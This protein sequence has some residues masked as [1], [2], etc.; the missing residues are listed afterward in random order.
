MSGSIP[1]QLGNLSNLQGLYLSSNQL[2]GV[3][4]SG[5]TQLTSLERFAFGDNAGLCAPTDAAFQNWLTAIPNEYLPAGVT[6]LG[7][8]CASTSEAPTISALTSGADFLT[9][10][11]AAPSGTGGPAITAYDLRHIPTAADEAADANW[12]VVDDAWTAGDGALSYRISGL[13]DGIRYDVQV[14]AGTASGDG[15]WSA[16]ASGTPATWGA[17]RSFSPPAVAPRGQVE[18][19]ITAS[20]IGGFGRVVEMLPAGFVYESSSLPNDSVEVNGREIGFTLFGEDSLTYTVTAPDALG[21][22]AFSGVVRNA[23]QE[24]V[25]VGGA[26]AIAVST[27]DPLILRYDANG[28]GTI[29]RSEVIRAINDYLFGGGSITRADVIR[30]INLYLFG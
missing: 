21:T 10:T 29:E 24:E 12:A 14:R 25:P 3:L 9:V 19:T 11:W 7:P 4:P 27:G 2:T 18:V 20:G 6:P 16:T 8:N 22:Y 28:N 13:A 26:L 1:S 23:A 15:P 5:F 17:V 30:L